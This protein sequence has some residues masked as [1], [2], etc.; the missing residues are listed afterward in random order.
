MRSGIQIIAGIGCVALIVVGMMQPVEHDVRWLLCLWGAAPLMGA[1]AWASRSTMPRGFSR[2]V[3]NLGLVIAVG[4][5]LLSMQLLRQQIV[6]ADATYHRVHVDPETG[7]VTSNV[8]PVLDSQRVIRGTIFDRTGMELVRSDVVD[9]GFAHRVY[10]VATIYNP[11]AF[12]NI[13]GFFSNRFGQS[14]LEYTYDDYLGGERGSVLAKLQNQMLGEPQEGNHLHLSLDVR[15][16]ARAWELLGGSYGSIVVLNPQTGA[17]LAMA[18]TPGFDPR[19]LSFN[20]AAEDWNAEHQRVAQFWKQ[21]TSADSGQ[22]LLNRPT[23]GQYPP[24]STFKTVTA[25]AALKY[26]AA[27]EPDNI[28]CMDEYKPE[29]ASPP[30]VNAV[31]HGLSSLTGDPSNL[32]KVYAYS[33]NVAF[34]QYAVRLGADRL[35]R[36]AELFDIYAPHNA[37]D[38]YDH[39]TDLV[40]MPSLLYVEPAFLDRPAA[41]A[42]TGYG[43]GQLLVTPLQMAMVAA[44]IANDGVMMRPYLVERIMPPEGETSVYDHMPREIRSTMSPGIAQEMRDT[45]RAVGEYGFGSVIN[46]HAPPG[47]VFGGKSGTGEHVPGATPHAWFIAIAPVDAPRYA[48]AVMVERGGEGSGIAA[49]LAGQILRAAFDLE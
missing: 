10:P 16:Q 33:C 3:H 8:R 7:Q 25:V 39:F 44:A 21:I 47:V 20:Y 37:P 22:P 18:S 38:V 43:Q 46:N 41:L 34:A 49:Q 29:P 6:Q 9:E 48:V 24:G 31:R 40:T 5:V 23:Q 28:R 32:E 14:G 11:A 1:I 4:F 35:T 12:S 19:G 42:D 13:V 15:L 30:V 36:Q 2:S 17:V 26:P 27:A 45:M